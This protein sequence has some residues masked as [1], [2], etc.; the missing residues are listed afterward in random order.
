MISMNHK[1][2]DVQR[3]LRILKRQDTLQ[4]LQVLWHCHGQLLSLESF[5]QKRRP[6]KPDQQE[7]Y[8]Q[9]PNQSNTACYCRESSE[10]ALGLPSRAYSHGL[11]SRPL[12]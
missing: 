1:E 5:T 3:K 2:R 7:A 10:F 8:S 9:E 4:S 11:V 12:S 6:S